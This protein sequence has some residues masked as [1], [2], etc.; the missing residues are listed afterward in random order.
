MSEN[1]DLYSAHVITR[2]ELEEIILASGG[3]LTERGPVGRISQDRTKHVFIWL[4]D[5][6][7]IPGVDPLYGTYDL[8]TRDLLRMKLGAEPRY[9]LAIE[10]GKTPGSGLL[11]V[12]FALACTQH[13]PCVVLAPSFDSAHSSLPLNEQISIKVFDQ[14]DMVELL[15]ERRGFITHGM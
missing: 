10:I 11:A 7:A 13:W 14:K 2:K 15:R 3:T 1:I 12:Q 4:A 9:V 5:K 6:E 8:A